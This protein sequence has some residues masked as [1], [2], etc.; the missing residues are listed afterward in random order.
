[1]T[2]WP[3]DPTS[4]GTGLPLEGVRVLDLSKILAGP[5]CVLVAADLGADV[6]KVEPP[7]E[8]DKVR[9]LKPPV[10]GEDATYYLSVNRNRRSIAVDL[11][12]TQGRALVAT[13]ARSCDAVVE[14]YLPHQLV[15][16]GLATLRDELSDVV[17]ISIRGA[18]ATGPLADAP[19]FDLLAQAR[20]GLMSVT[21]TPDGPPLKVGAPL[22]D[23]VTGL[24]GACALL[25]G[26]YARREG[27]RAPRMEV[28]LLEATMTALVNQVQG[29]LATGEEPRRLG[30]DHPSI[31]PYGPVPT[32]DGTLFVA[33]VSS[34]QFEALCKVIERPL[35]ADPR[36]STNARRVEHRAELADELRVVFT[37]RS[38]QT[39]SDLLGDAGVPCGPVHTVASAVEDPQIRDGGFVTT[40]TAPAGTFKMLRSPIRVDGE[41]LPIRRPPPTIDQ[42][43][44]DIR[45]AIGHSS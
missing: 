37:G 8:G 21:G 35:G 22:A 28:P 6:I 19:S 38:T 30:N 41:W 29:Y 2:A 33:V 12:T 1:V 45:L 23:V 42:D 24:Y 11:A 43:G 18:A 32:S 39:W 4:I 3:E 9:L 26:L 34:T 7:G 10:F 31:A 17:W 27:R 14:N 25:A 5:L 40:A 20:S 16:L 13:L 36:F 44:D 15:D